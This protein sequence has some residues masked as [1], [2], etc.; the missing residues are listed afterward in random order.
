MKKTIA[1]LFVLFSACN[2]SFGQKDTTKPKP[3]SDTIPVL[4]IKDVSNYVE[5]L[6][7][8]ITYNQFQLILNVMQDMINK[9]EQELSQSKKK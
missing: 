1:I 9:K 5:S 4:S 7:D 3:L 8:K 6:K 2:L